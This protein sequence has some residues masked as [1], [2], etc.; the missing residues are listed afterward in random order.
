[1]YFLMC[2]YI[3]IHEWGLLPGMDRYKDMTVVV[4]NK[5]FPSPTATSFTLEGPDYTFCGQ[6]TGIPAVGSTLVFTCDGA[7]IFGRYVYVYLPTLKQ[8]LTLC[9]VEIFAIGKYHAIN[10]INRSLAVWNVLDVE[11]FLLPSLIIKILIIG[12]KK[13][14]QS[15]TWYHTFHIWHC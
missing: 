1:M 2:V 10:V 9:E 6:N 5:S 13:W 15:S 12:A 14:Y 3:Y 8:A 7:P 11:P 4:S